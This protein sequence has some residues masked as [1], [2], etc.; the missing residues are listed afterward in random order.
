MSGELL[1]DATGKNAEDRFAA[2]RAEFFRRLGATGQSRTDF[3]HR[4]KPGDQ[5]EPTEEEV[6]RRWAARME[7]SVNDICIGIQRAFMAAADRHLFV[8]SFR[9]CEP[10]I[11]GRVNELRES[12]AGLAPSC[13]ETGVRVNPAAAER[14]R[15]REE[16]RRVLGDKN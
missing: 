9:Y 14:I 8:T 12:R 13:A 4:P 3:Y 11:V 1:R 16:A 5:L 7:V 2:I 15:A 10:Q 6:A